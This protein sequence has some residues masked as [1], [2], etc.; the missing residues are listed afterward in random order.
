MAQDAPPGVVSGA[1]VEER[2][3]RQAESGIRPRPPRFKAGTP[4]LLQ[5]NH[6]L[7]LVVTL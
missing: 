3:A 4:K 1:R 2:E 5:H 6:S 7:L